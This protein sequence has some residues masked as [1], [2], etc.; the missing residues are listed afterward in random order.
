[1]TRAKLLAATF[2][3]VLM[4]GMGVLSARADSHE[5]K[6]EGHDRDGHGRSSHSDRKGHS[7][8]DGHGRGERGEHGDHDG[9]HGHDH[10]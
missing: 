1:M 3:G 9:G 2:S 6:H 7:D 8:H 10:E 5:G 4:L